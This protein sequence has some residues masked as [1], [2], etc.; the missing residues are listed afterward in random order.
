MLEGGIGIG[1]GKEIDVTILN[2][3]AKGLH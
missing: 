1:Y 2:R 3:V